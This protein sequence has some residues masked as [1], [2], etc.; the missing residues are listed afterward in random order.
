MATF[1]T[2]HSVLAQ[3]YYFFQQANTSFNVKE[4]ILK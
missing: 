2:V 4:L 1:F 3:D